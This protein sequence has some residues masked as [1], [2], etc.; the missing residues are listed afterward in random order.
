M[1]Y[2]R[3]LHGYDEVCAYVDGFAALTESRNAFVLRTSATNDIM[4]F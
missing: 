3:E 4:S 2:R 1:D